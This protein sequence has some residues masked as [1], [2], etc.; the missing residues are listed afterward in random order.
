MSQIT[1]GYKKI[2][3]NFINWASTQNNII[4]VMIIGSQARDD[5]PADKWSDLDLWIITTDP[6]LYLS[7]T[8]WIEKIE[9]PLITFQQGVLDSGRERKVLFTNGLDVDFAFDTPEQFQKSLQDTTILDIIRRGIN[10]ILDK[11]GEI[12][13]AINNLPQFSFPKPPTQAEFHELIHI[14]W[15]RA[16][17]AAKRLRRGE[18]WVGKRSCDTTMKELL[19]TIIEWH[20]RA[21]NG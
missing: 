16:Q 10:I 6:D 3:D 17:W 7:A 5:H 13:Q 9:K 14:F 11:D 4:G 15:Y 2:V 20:T 19:I 8:G 18:L 21:S 1:Q 12:T